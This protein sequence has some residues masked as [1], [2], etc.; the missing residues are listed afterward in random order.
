[1]EKASSDTEAT[2]FEH[3]DTAASCIPHVSSL[4][5]DIPVHGEG[6]H[7]VRNETKSPL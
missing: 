4:S 1:M 6:P 2:V 7:V 3:V 5:G